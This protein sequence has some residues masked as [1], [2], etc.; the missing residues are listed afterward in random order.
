MKDLKDILYG[1]HIQAVLGGTSQSIKSIS[2][3][4]RLCSSNDLFFAL[5]GTRVDGHDFIP[6]VISQGCTAIV[7]QRN[8]DV[9]E[10]PLC[11][12]APR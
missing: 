10:G 12:L 11:V 9:P 3:D 5:T 2:A 6:Q 7:A 8:V 4:S 1:I